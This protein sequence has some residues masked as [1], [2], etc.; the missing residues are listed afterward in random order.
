MEKRLDKLEQKV[1]KILEQQSEMNSILAVNTSSLS[2]HMRRTSA[3]ENQVNS[4]PQKALIYI[5]LLGGILTILSR[6]I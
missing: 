6:L 5:S 3:L 4:L 1:D 2:E